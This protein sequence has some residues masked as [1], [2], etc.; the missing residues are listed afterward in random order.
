TVVTGTLPAGVIATGSELLG[1]GGAVRVRSVESLNA[2]RERV[3]GSTRVA[4]NLTGAVA[5]LGRGDALWQAGAWQLTDVV[6]VRLLTGTG[7]VPRTPMR[8]IGSRATQVRMQALDDSHARLPLPDPVPLRQGDRTVLRDPGD[9][10]LWGALVVDPDP[11]PLGA[12]PR[13]GGIPPRV[14]R[15]QELHGRGAQPNL[16]AEVRARGVV[17]R[18][19]LRRLG[20]QTGGPSPWV[21]SPAW[22]AEAS[23]RIAEIVRHH[24]RREP[25]NPGLAPTEIVNAL[26]E[27]GLRV[28]APEL[29]AELLSPDLRVEEGKVTSRSAALPPEVEAALAKLLAGC[30]Q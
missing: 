5:G 12:L 30:E 26:A 18:D 3:A 17:H 6:D 16:D 19:T 14:A 1:P 15:A 27:Y 24:D 20:I 10:R 8:H 29:I 9:R 25:L 23:E 21:M 7:R 4:L 28:P 2:P 22:Q 13:R 11:A